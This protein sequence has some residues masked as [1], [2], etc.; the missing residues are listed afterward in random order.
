MG[1]EGELR[2]D[3]GRPSG[4]MRNAFSKTAARIQVSYDPSV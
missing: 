3:L 4:N 1:V 2:F